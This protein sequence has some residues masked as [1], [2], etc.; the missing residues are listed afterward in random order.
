MDIVRL[1]RVHEGALD[2]REEH[3][4]DRQH[5]QHRRRSSRA[6]SPGVT[7]ADAEKREPEAFEDRRQRIELR[8][9][10]V[11]C[12]HGGQRIDHRRDVHQQLNAER[13]EI[14]QVAIARRQRAD[15]DAAAE[16][17]AGE[18]QRAEAASGAPRSSR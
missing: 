3:Q 4:P 11:T 17:V 15:D 16:R 6:S 9:P 2:A 7:R 12:R 5:D 18:N 1:H 13:D 14:A 10:A 8:R